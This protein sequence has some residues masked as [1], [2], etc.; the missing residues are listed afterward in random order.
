M[1]DGRAECLASAFRVTAAQTAGGTV[2]D[3]YNSRKTDA[4]LEEGKLLLTDVESEDL[5]LSEEGD[6]ISASH[7][8]WLQVEEARGVVGNAVVRLAHL[9]EAVRGLTYPIHFIDFETSRPA[10]PFHAGRRPYEQLLF[11]FSHHRLDADGSV[12]HQT[13]HLADSP[14]VLPNFDTVRALKHAL[15][16]DGGS[17]LHWWDHERTVLGEVREQLLA[18]PAGHVPD[19]DGLVAFIDSLLGT[20]EAPGRLFDPGRLVHRS[21]FFPGTRGSSSLKKVLPAL[22]T[23]SAQLRDRYAA[24]SYGSADGA[25]SLNFVGQ[26]W[27]QFDAN[28]A[29]I[30][31][32]KLLGERTE[33]PDLTGLE[34]REEDD[35]AVADGGAAMVA[36]G[37]LQSG[38]LDE[39]ARQRLRSQLLRYCELDTLAMV[40]AW[41]GLHEVLAKVKS[42]LTTA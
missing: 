22:L 13:Q 35:K 7:R 26:A 8:Q 19:R 34:L 14:A 20:R 17:V 42:P 24:P 16:G 32:Y 6:V 3:L 5:K 15:E 33:D 12:R 1:R 23:S 40:M 38:L 28:G 31:P 9:D 39:P 21:A 29:V 11:Q 41:E 25:P 36:Y 2:L 18:L 27:V 4:F 37:L 10:L 30:D